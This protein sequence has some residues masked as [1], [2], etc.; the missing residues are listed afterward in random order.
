MLNKKL[1][2]NM[3]QKGI[4]SVLTRLLGE[5]KL[6]S[7]EIIKKIKILV[8]KIN[9]NTGLSLDEAFLG[10]SLNTMERIIKKLTKD[11]PVIII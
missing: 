7:L 5:T 3:K 10:V 6:N 2:I 11:I 1:K 8:T 9:R 4:I